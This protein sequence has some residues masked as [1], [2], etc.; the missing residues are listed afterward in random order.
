MGKHKIASMSSVCRLPC[1]V[2]MHIFITST[3]LL[4]PSIKLF[5]RL[6]FFLHKSSSRFCLPTYQPADLP[7]QTT[8]MNMI[9]F[10]IQK[11]KNT[12]TSKQLEVPYYVH[13]YRHTYGRR[14]VYFSSSFSY[15][16]KRVYTRYALI[17]HTRT[18]TLSHC[19]LYLLLCTSVRILTV[20]TYTYSE[21]LSHSAYLRYGWV[22]VCVNVF[23]YYSLVIAK[24][25]CQ[26]LDRL[27][28]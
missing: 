3:S 5:L 6:T 24:I 19:A 14:Y 26:S 25:E 1:V 13:T 4:A 10:C 28:D 8:Y 12:S 9:G 27:I 22:C 11:E 20:N 21:R 7:S 17:T 16:D 15:I 2:F 18:S 23:I